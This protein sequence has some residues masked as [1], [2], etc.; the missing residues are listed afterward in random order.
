MNI[1]F[2]SIT[3]KSLKISESKPTTVNMLVGSTKADLITFAL[4]YLSLN[5]QQYRFDLN[6]I[7]IMS[8]MSSRR[9]TSVHLPPSTQSSYFEVSSRR[10]SITS[11]STLRLTVA[12]VSVPRSYI[13]ILPTCLMNLKSLT[14]SMSYIKWRLEAKHLGICNT[15][16]FRGWYLRPIRG[17]S[18]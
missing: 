18:A 6:W 11:P 2:D 4:T 3:H 8:V 1:L 10:D 13:F 7:L 15:A 9:V 14:L 16:S 5:G 17:V 12:R